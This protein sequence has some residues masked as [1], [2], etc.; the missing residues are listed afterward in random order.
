M[1]IVL[2]G[3]VSFSERTLAALIRNGADV[4]GVLGLDPSASKNV[5]DYSDLAPLAA[6]ANIPYR[7][8]TKINA[9]EIVHAVREWQ[10][11]V[12]FVVG[13]SQL[14]H[15]EMMRIPRMGGIGFHPTRLPKG[16]GRAP[17]AWL[18]H[19]EEDGAA[20]FFVLENDADAGAIFV[21]EPFRVERG[22]YA[23]EV[24]QA[25]RDAID[26]ALDR[27]LP[28]LLS[29]EWNPVPQNEAEASWFGRRAA[30][31][32]HI[33]WSQPAAD[34][35]RLVRTV[36]RPYPGAYTYARGEKVTVWRAS[37]SDLPY[38]GVIGRVLAVRDG[39]AL[40]QTGR[41]LLSLEEYE[42]AALAVGARLGYALE[43]EI[44][45]LRNRLRTVEEAI[46]GK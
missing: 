19:D 1:R 33:D 44:H 34:I 26:R 16:R 2:A 37:E 7:P 4:A 21:Q 6:S 38:R 27:W 24:I 3:S 32:G 29:G 25:V 11:D 36:S 23:Q 30:E 20:S 31:D 18:T 14:V 46:K 41:G 35:A 17:V 39:S 10:P 42:P 8:F 22:A 5:S 40:V 43:D 45:L 12:L 9:P 13:L 28:R 15:E